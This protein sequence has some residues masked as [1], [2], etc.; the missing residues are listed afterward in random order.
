M[1]LPV[2][3]TDWSGGHHLTNQRTVE[4]LQRFPHRFIFS[5]Y[6]HATPHIKRWSLSHLCLNLGWSQW[7]SWPTVYSR[8]DAVWLLEQLPTRS[9]RAF[10]FGTQLQCC[11]E[12]MDRP[13][14]R[15]LE[16]SP[17]MVWLSSRLTPRNNLL[18]MWMCHLGNGSSSPISAAP[19]DAT[20]ATKLS[21]AQIPD[22]S[23]M[24]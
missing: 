14:W 3:I 1:P 17:L 2:S 20:G 18:V 13:M 21:P 5:L 7:I 19:A 8:H 22:S 4:R 9:L 15:G 6:A 24:R 11:K 10:A 23:I 12:A 16:V